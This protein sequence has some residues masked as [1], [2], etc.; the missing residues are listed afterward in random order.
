ML[1]FMKKIPKKT[2]GSKFWKEFIEVLKKT[3]TSA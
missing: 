3:N 1:R 2:K